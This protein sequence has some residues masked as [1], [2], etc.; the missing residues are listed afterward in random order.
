MKPM[1]ACVSANCS[2]QR[3]VLRD[4]EDDKIKS[5]LA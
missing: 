4:V 1:L 3:F 5:E 2:C